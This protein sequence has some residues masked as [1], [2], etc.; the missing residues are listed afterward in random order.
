[1]LPQNYTFSDEQTPPLPG[2]GVSAAFYLY[3][4]G[5]RRLYIRIA[6]NREG[7]EAISIYLLTISLL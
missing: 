3:N 2:D 1:M 7:E 4:L 6:S 5:N